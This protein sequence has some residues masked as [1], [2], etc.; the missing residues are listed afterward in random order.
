M[1]GDK[2]DG[3]PNFLSA[4]DTFITNARQSPLSKKKLEQWI[5]LEPEVFC[6]TN[7]LRN[8]ARN[9]A[10]VDLTCIPTN[11]KT[12]IIEQ[13]E[14]TQPSDRSRLFNYFIDKRLKNLMELIGEF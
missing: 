9:R 7:M 14:T 2:G 5:D 13:F 4:D 12:Q 8:Y 1:R 11:I 6:N 10:M 3:V